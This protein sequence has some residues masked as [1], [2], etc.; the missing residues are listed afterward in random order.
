MDWDR[1]GGRGQPITEVA[2]PLICKKYGFT[3]VPEWQQNPEG[4]RVIRPFAKVGGE[5]FPLDFDA[6]GVLEKGRRHRFIEAAR[7]ASPAFLADYPP[8]PRTKKSKPEASCDAT[9]PPKLDR[10]FFKQ[11]SLAEL[12]EA[13]RALEATV[14][15]RAREEALL[16]EIRAAEEAVANLQ[17]IAKLSEKYG[18][19]PTPELSAELEKAQARLAEFKQPA[20]VV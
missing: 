18:I 1:L 20:A 6:E 14:G 11:Y 13:K 15:E 9:S 7:R 8:F 2:M 3:Y 12:E 16:K 17:T 19:K 10:G 5:L 4:G